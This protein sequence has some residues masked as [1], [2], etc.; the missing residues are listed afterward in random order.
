MVFF[1]FLVH[2]QH[3]QTG[4]ESSSEPEVRGDQEEVNFFLLFE[5]P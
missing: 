4:R 2:D 3:Q 1:S 5:V